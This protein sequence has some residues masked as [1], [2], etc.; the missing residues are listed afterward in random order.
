MCISA[1]LLGWKMPYWATLPGNTRPG[2]MPPSAR[3]PFCSI[4]YPVTCEPL[5]VQATCPVKHLTVS[6]YKYFYTVVPKVSS[7]DTD[8]ATFFPEEFCGQARLEV[9]NTI[10]LDYM[11]LPM[12]NCV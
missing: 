10:R 2:G 3:C 6:V 1:L 4:Y 7:E 9:L 11:K 5:G 12:F 8:T